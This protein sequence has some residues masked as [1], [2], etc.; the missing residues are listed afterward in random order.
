MNVNRYFDKDC[1]KLFPQLHNLTKIELHEFT[2]GDAYSLLQEI[3]KVEYTLS[4]WY[5]DLFLIIGTDLWSEEQESYIKHELPEIKS[6]KLDQFPLVLDNN[7]VKAIWKGK[8]A[9]F[10]YDPHGK[11]MNILNLIKTNL[12]KENGKNGGRVLFEV[13]SKIFRD[14]LY[15]RDIQAFYQQMST[16]DIVKSL[17]VV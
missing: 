11:G 3:I 14:P 2:L 10:Q 8:K 13:I 5:F 17:Q 6:L 12:E 4:R 15:L 9:I 7:S 16:D 1:S